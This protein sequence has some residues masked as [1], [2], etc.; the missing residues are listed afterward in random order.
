[1]L[2]GIAAESK[3]WITEKLEDGDNMCLWFPERVLGSEF[4]Y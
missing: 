4:L 1:M 2:A 3:A